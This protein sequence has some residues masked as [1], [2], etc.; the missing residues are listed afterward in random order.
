MAKLLP[1]VEQALRAPRI[2]SQQFL[3]TSWRRSGRRPRPVWYQLYLV[4]GRE[5]AEAGLERARAAGF[6]ALAVTIDTG[7]AGMRE[8]DVRNARPS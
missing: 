2:F 3:G 4:G 8:R 1:L 6:S 7:T 5:A